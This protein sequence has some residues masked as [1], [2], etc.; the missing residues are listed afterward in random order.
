MDLPEPVPPTKITSPR[1]LRAICFNTGGRLRLSKEGILLV[2]ARSTNAV[3]PRCTMAFTRKRL[4]SGRL[5]AKLH[6]LVLVNSSICLGLMM[7]NAISMQ[8][9]AVS[10]SSVMGTIL[11]STF[12]AGGKL[13]VTKRSEPLYLLRWRSQLKSASL[14]D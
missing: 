10:G 9:S 4:V 3:A 6:S 7:L 14:A 11:P 8:R 5:M 1:F 2:M 12:M 13:V